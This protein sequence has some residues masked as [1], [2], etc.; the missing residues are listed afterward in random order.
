LRAR[1][2]PP[3]DHIVAIGNAIRYDTV[4]RRFLLALLLGMAVPAVASAAQ[5]KLRSTSAAATK[6]PAKKPTAKRSRT[7]TKPKAKAK[8]TAEKPAPE[9]T[10]K[11]PLP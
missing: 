2:D 6:P 1:S 8:K 4:V 5:V 9:K 11:R 7:A 3:G 10:P